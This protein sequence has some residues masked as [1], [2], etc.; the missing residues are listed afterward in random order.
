MKA[1]LLALS[2]A[3][4]VVAVGS[5]VWATNHIPPGANCC[6]EDELLVTT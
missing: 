6:V 3:L 5:L 1:L 4:V 2:I